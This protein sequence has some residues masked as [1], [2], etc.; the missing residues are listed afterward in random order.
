MTRGVTRSVICLYG[1]YVWSLVWPGRAVVTMPTVPD[2][3][4]KVGDLNGWDDQD[5]TLLLEEGR[6]KL[7][8]QAVRFDRIRAT[9]QVLLPL[10][11][12]LLVVVGASLRRL[13][14]D[15]LPPW[16]AYAAWWTSATLVVL[17]ALGA[18]AL[19]TAKA[20]FGVILP[21]KLS[22]EQPPILDVLAQEHAEQMAVGERTINDR[23]T[24]QRVAVQ[25]LLL[26]GALH[27]ALWALLL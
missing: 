21:T 2:E 6:R 4:T 7:D 24:I 22:L 14:G 3:M 11:V 1:S 10:A 13:P 5:K 25:L 8:Q 27:L 19:L 17:S 26:G 15:N 9:A 18:A 23:L 12:A 20:V 16:L